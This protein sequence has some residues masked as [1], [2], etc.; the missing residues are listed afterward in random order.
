MSKLTSIRKVANDSLQAELQD[1]VVHPGRVN[2]LA[3]LNKGDSRFQIGNP[4]RAWF[5]ITLASL[6]ELGLKASQLEAITS[7]ESSQK[8]VIDLE[9][10]KVNGEELKIQVNETILPDFYQK[11]NVMKAAKQISITEKIAANR[12]MK[13]SYDLSKYIGQSGYFLDKD[14]NHIFSRTTVTVASQ[15]NSFFIEG[16]L[17]PEKEL[18]SYG[19]TLAE[20]VSVEQ[21]EEVK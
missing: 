8:V 9:S 13:T 2:V 17:V 4:R 1:V 21:F 11:N 20:P 19:A 5:P 10:P 15:V 6:A 7:M 3:E 16:E 14:G 12:G 18:A